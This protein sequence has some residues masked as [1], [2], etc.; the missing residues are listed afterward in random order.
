MDGERTK[1]L[2]RE[3]LLGD[4]QM[5]FEY[6]LENVNYTLHTLNRIQ[7]FLGYKAIKGL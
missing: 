4:K 3:E 2:S 1:N 7:P 6:I 5:A